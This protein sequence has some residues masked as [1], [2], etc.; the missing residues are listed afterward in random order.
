MTFFIFFSYVESLVPASLPHGYN[1]ISDYF[2]YNIIFITN[3]HYIYYPYSRD[4]LSGLLLLLWSFKKI[5]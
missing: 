4:A 5:S 2:C 1:I 3:H